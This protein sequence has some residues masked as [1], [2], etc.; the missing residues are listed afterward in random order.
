VSPKVRLEGNL[1][2]KKLEI[3]VTNGILLSNLCRVSSIRQVFINLKCSR[4]RGR[5]SRKEVRP[6]V[7]PAPKKSSRCISLTMKRKEACLQSR[8]STKTSIVIAQ[9][10]LSSNRKL[11]HP[12]ILGFCLLGSKVFHL[13]CPTLPLRNLI[14]SSL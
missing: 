12:R 9:S 2:Y 7:T 4:K 13:D 14:N 3:I 10:P 8:G 11:S 6:G 5:T 1:L